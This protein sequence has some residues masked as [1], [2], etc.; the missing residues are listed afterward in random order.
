MHQ[1]GLALGHQLHPVRPE[2]E[3]LAQ[4]GQDGDVPGGPVP[5][6]EVLSH[7]HG[8]RA[9]TVDEDQADELLGTQRGEFL[10]EGQHAHGVGA[11]LPQECDPAVH[12]SEH[13]RGTAAQHL[14]R[15]GVEGDHDHR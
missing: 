2:P 9:E 12:L 3:L 1:D 4:A 14:F 11:P 10:G 13:R 8:G 7:H 15:V 5:E 6:P